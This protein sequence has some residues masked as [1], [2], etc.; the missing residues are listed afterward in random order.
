MPS[1]GYSFTF[2]KI[3]QANPSEVYNAFTNSTHLREWMCNLATVNPKPG[4]YIFVAWNQGFYAC[5]EFTE[6]KPDEKIV[7]SWFGRGEPAPTLVT[8]HLAT[9]DHGTQ[10][11]LEH[12]GFGSG[13]EWA[14]TIENIQAGWKDGLDNLASVLET[15]QD[16]RFILRPMLGI[17]M[18]DFDADI[19]SKL[20][21][22]VSEGI[23]IDNLIDGM[24]AAAAGL[25]SDDVII[26]IGGKETVSYTDISTALQSHRAGDVVEVIFYRGNQKM[27]LP[28][29]LSRRSLPE[30]PPS[31]QALSELLHKRNEQLVD[32]LMEFV[33]GVTDFEADFKP[34]NEEWNIKEILAHLI[35]S[36]RDYQ[37]FIAQVVGE[38]EP[39]YDDYAG[40]LQARVEATVAAY[41]T[42]SGIVDE[43]K[44]SLLESEA[45]LARLP[46]EVTEKKSG[47]W[48]ICY[49]TLDSPIHSNSHLEQMRA[50]ALAART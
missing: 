36:E 35:H 8:V 33:A 32:E 42:L 16:M 1:N 27:T 44:R 37:N 22:P 10:V 29:I 34:E 43:F 31:P 14:Q 23:R 12:S 40:N 47:Y 46:I 28:L 45:L 3:I 26:K 20:G 11:R 9:H 4:G 49:N 24:G 25:Q 13:G 15:G 39:Q 30:I 21:V 5:G 2:S 19:A 7:F 38:Q 41:P 18:N 17:G 50:A 48:R 6:L